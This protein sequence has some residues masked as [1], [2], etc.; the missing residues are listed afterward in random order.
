[1]GNVRAAVA[2]CGLLQLSK[3]VKPCYLTA[4]KRLSNEFGDTIGAE[5]AA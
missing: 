4:P 2:R 5:P 1:M 3:V